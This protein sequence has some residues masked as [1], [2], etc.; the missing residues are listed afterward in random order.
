M[1]WWRALKGN[2]LLIVQL[3]G[4]VLAVLALGLAGWVLWQ[5]RTWAP[6]RFDGEE[7]AFT[8]RSIGTEF[9][10]LPV[11]KVLPI[12]FP[13]HFEPRKAAGIDWIDHFGFIRRTDPD[14]QRAHHGL[15]VGFTI[16]HYQPASASPSPVPFVG[17]SCSACH[18]LQL[19]KPGEKP[20]RVLI[21]AGNAALDLIPFFEAFR[22]ALLLREP[23]ERGLEKIEAGQP[24]RPYNQ[25]AIDLE[26]S[27]YQYVL[28]MARIESELAK[29][30]IELGALERFFVSQWLAGVR[31]AALKTLPKYEE[32]YWGHEEPYQGRADARLALYNRVGPGRTQPFK[33]L[34]NFIL[35]LPVNANNGYSKVPAVFH[36]D[37]HVWAQFD[38]SIRDHAAR[39]ALAAMTAGATPDSLDQPELSHNIRAAADYT[40]ALRG[41][42]FLE[43]FPEEEA[44]LDRQKVSRGAKVYRQHC[45]G[46]HGQPGVKPGSWEY[47]ASKYAGNGAVFDPADKGP[48][49]GRVVPVAILGTDPARVTFRYADIL[50]FQLY[51][52]YTFKTEIGHPYEEKGGY[53]LVH[54]LLFAREDIRSTG[55]YVNAP[56][57]SAFARAPYLHNASILTL[58]ELINLEPRR[59]VFYRGKNAYDTRK[60]GLLSPDKPDADHYYRFDTSLPGNH[61]AGHD[62]PWRY[63]GPGWDRAALED[64]LEYLKTF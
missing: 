27:D 26:E 43:Y 19:R 60:V 46:C 10:P 20:R 49:H 61:S 58:A 53:P 21:G 8:D 12:I 48:Q 51:R 4:L 56:V 9:I 30:Q 52:R 36:E 16:T 23:N 1:S 39:S 41:G 11:L 17:L 2:W 62:Y 32:P 55:G 63:R 54:S 42:T 40:R 33:T 15:P 38:G 34:A 3:A 7:A 28:N 45:A 14:D 44:R 57:D 50:P 5:E 6:P 13:Q 29:L 24:D 64:L 22:A 31:A 25:D 47:D 35:N 59:Q 18:S 37:L